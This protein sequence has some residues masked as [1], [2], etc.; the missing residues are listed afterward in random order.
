MGGLEATV[1]GG[2]FVEQDRQGRNMF[3]QEKGNAVVGEFGMGWA[4]IAPGIDNEQVFVGNF[5]SGEVIKYRL[6]DSE[7]S[8]RNN[9]SEKFSLSGVA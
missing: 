2:Y 7:V 3:V 5:F 1:G 6:A 9:I 8:G 4:A